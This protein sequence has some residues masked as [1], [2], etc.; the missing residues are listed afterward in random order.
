[1]KKYSFKI[2]YFEYK[3]TFHNY[4]KENLKFSPLINQISL[5]NLIADILKALLYLRK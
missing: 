2:Y 5:L 4:V 3:F 1:M